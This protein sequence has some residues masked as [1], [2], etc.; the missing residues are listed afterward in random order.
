MTSAPRS[1][2]WLYLLALFQLVAGPLV[3]VTVMTFC[4]VTVREA[5]SQGLVKAMSAALQS[6]EVQALVQVTSNAQTED[7][8]SSLPVK[9]FKAGEKK[10]IGIAWESMPTVMVDATKTSSSSAWLKT[11]SPAWPQAPPGTPPRAV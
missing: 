7:S 6:D 10:F 11:W 5:P 8:K 4:K 9:K 1:T 2:R 3:L